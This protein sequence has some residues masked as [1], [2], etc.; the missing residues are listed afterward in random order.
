M[1][2]NLFKVWNYLVVCTT[3]VFIFYIYY[4]KSK[5]NRIISKEIWNY[6][7]SNLNICV[8]KNPLSNNDIVVI[9]SQIS[10]KTIYHCNNSHHKSLEIAN[11]DT[12]PLVL[13]VYSYIT[14]FLFQFHLCKGSH[15]S[16]FKTNRSWR[17]IA[18]EMIRTKPNLKMS[19][20][21]TIPKWKMNLFVILFLYPSIITISIEKEFQ[22]RRLYNLWYIY[23]IHYRCWT[24]GAKGQRQSLL[25]GNVGD[26]FFLIFLL[27]FRVRLLCF[28]E[29]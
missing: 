3:Q 24:A 19:Q 12:H 1:E 8:Y 9:L 22:V 2:R 17:R 4:I 21:Q 6:E 25:L 13:Y 5:W 18:K 10:I 14:S 29:W 27:N 15:I 23:F 26:I 28:F 16:I 20:F 7:I 11:L